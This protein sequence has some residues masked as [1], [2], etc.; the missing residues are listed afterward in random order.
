LTTAGLAPVVVVPR[1][2]VVVPVAARRDLEENINAGGETVNWFGLDGPVERM[3]VEHVSSS[4]SY[5][6]R[7][8]KYQ[9][10]TS[11]G[12]DVIANISGC[13]I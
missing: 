1:A 6:R 2:L 13:A 8:P 11:R 10:M 12:G 9:R 7:D 4:C 3:I 5:M